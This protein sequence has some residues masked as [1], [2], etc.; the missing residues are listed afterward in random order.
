MKAENAT[1]ACYLTNANS[2]PSWV[3]RYQDP[4]TCGGP[5]LPLYFNWSRPGI[6]FME[7]ATHK[8]ALQQ[9]GDS[10]RVQ[11]AVVARRKKGKRVG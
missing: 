7:A 2:V 8:L 6:G 4:V 10:S 1:A 5:V 3:Q 9:P 11:L